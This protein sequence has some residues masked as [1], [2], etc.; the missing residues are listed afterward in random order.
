MTYKNPPVKTGGFLICLL[1]FK[2]NQ[3]TALL[4]IEA[5][6]ATSASQLDIGLREMAE[7]ECFAK[8]LRYSY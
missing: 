1:H 5:A 6:Q 8:F 4:G 3:Q 7:D 2:T